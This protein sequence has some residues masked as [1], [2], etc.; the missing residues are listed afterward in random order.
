[1]ELDT[2]IEYR[3]TDWPVDAVPMVAAGVYTV[4]RGTAFIYVGMSGRNW[5]QSDIAAKRDQR[6]RKGLWERLNSHASGR[7]SGDQFCVYICDRFIVPNLTSNE[8]SAVGGGSILLDQYTKSF[9]H[10]EL[11]FRFVEVEDGQTAY[12][13]ERRVQTG[14][15]PIG[16]PL[17]NPL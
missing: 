1:M 15:L 10:E 13:L 11:S 7:R 6:K 4:F 2:G 14:S 16:K 5:S 8:L 3:F 12:D 9:I 17:L